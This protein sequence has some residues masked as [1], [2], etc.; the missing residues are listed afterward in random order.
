MN[1]GM[2]WLVQEQVEKVGCGW[3]G[4]SCDKVKVTEGNGKGLGWIAEEDCCGEAAAG[5]VK[6]GGVA[7]R[8]GRER[9][10]CR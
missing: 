4:G 6:E 5:G 8:G 10:R 3:S 2:G 7:W 9:E 1:A